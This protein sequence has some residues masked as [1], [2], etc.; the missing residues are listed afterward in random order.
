MSVQPM[1]SL[2]RSGQKFLLRAELTGC[3]DES[4]ELC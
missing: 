4:Q 2:H 3:F 1:L